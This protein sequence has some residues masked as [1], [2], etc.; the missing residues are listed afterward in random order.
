MRSSSVPTCILCGGEGQPLYAGLVDRVSDAPGTWSI[1]QCRNAVCRTAWLDPAP[2]PEDIADAYRSYYTHEDPVGAAEES[3]ALRNADPILRGYLAQRYGWRRDAVPGWQRALAPLMRLR[4]SA[5]ANADFAML[6]VPPRPGGSLLEVGCGSGRL[7]AQ[8]RELGWK[9][10]G[11]DPDPVAVERARALDL[12]VRQ[13]TL[14]AQTLPSSSYDLVALVHVIEHVHDPVA[15]LE[16]CRRV[17]RPGGRLVFLTPNIR[18]LGHRRFGPAWFALEPP[19]HLHLFSPDSAERLAERAGFADVA[20]RTSARGAVQ[21]F[22]ASQSIRRT[23]RCV[24]GEHPDRL[25]SLRATALQ[26]LEW[27]LLQFRPHLGEE[28]VLCAAK[29]HD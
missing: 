19:R 10:T 6:H 17:L 29:P 16:E 21:L 23:G 20:V 11:V 9:V 25:P 2:D 24:W 3:P 26:V 27:V 28:I 4:P 5:R 8:M 15:L 14:E 1:R 22:L 12:D 13:G 7:L 18:A